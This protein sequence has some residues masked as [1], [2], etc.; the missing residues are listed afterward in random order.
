MID[1]C[2]SVLKGAFSIQFTEMHFGD[3]DDNVTASSS[4]DL[5]T[6]FDEDSGAENYNDGPT[7]H[8]CGDVRKNQ[9]WTSS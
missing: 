2:E 6:Y 4:L 7:H 5:N 3:L 9:L 8:S 1:C